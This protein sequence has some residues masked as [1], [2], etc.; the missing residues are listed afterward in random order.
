MEKNVVTLAIQHSKNAVGFYAYIALQLFH[1][2]HL[3]TLLSHGLELHKKLEAIAEEHKRNSLLKQS[4]QGEKI[5]SQLAIKE[6][7]LLACPSIDDHVLFLASL[8]A[9]QEEHVDVMYTQT[10]KEIL[11]KQLH[12]IE[13]TG[14]SFSL[15]GRQKEQDLILRVLERSFRNNVLLTGA[16]GIGK[17]TLAQSIV[18]TN[19]NLHI[20]QLFPGNTQFMNQ[21]I[22]L[23]SHVPE[24]KRILFLLD[25][26][27]TFD[28]TQLKYLIDSYQ[29]LATANNASYKKFSADYPA[30]TSKFEIVSLS[31]QPSDELLS[32]LNLHTQRISDQHQIS[33][34]NNLVKELITITKHYLPDPAFP[35]KGIAILEESAYLVKQQ[36]REQVLIDDVRTIVAQ[37]ANV[38]ITAITDF[39]KKELADLEEKLSNR[40]KGQS[41]AITKV[42]QTIQRSRLGLSKQQKPIGSFLFIGPSGVGK[43]ELAK[44]LASEVFGDTDA[45]VRLDMSEFAESHMV[46]R[47]IGSPPGYVGYEEGG[48]L[49]NPIKSKPYSLVLLDEIEKAHPRVFD[50]FLQVLDD[51]RLTDGQGTKVDFRHTIIVATSNAGLEDLL[52]LLEEKRSAA[53]VEKEIKELLSDYFRIEFLNRFDHIVIFN[54]L[55]LSELID[56][57]KL[58]IE[59]LKAELLKRN[60]QL[61]VSDETLKR[62]AKESLDPRFGARGMIRNIQD[63]IE[64]QLAEMIIANKISSGERI[65]F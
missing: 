57:G 20:V 25:E 24:G 34:E 43:T 31:E 63:S 59:K 62:L 26:L 35:A 44:A 46:Q 7:Q 55:G 47:L 38:P 61:F 11:E 32:I 17:T 56:I 12:K 2:T 36:G 3:S 23:L 19:P 8:R 14:L 30:I 45:F 4:H 58:H 28:V 10:L 37:K 41:Q 33:W 49:T 27:F 39:D 1:E 40:V 16:I 29:I 64:A 13:K 48:Q 18:H 22:S 65:E 50:M 42:V 54:A 53:D 5:L 6:Q 51:G 52:D 21:I 60:I 15:I 9:L